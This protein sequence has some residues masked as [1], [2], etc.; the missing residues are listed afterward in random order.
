MAPFIAS[1]KGASYHQWF[2]AFDQA[3]D[4]M[5]AFAI[6]I[7]NALRKKNIYYEDLVGG[8]ILQPLVITPMK[9]N[10][11]QDY[12]KSIGKVGGQNKVPRLS[13][14]RIIADALKPFI[15]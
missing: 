12:M 15:L 4:N 14:D 6:A 7:D 11:F 5:Q 2:I 13:N 8:G 9:K 1:D 3:P 10:A